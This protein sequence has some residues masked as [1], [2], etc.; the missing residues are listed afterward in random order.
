MKRL[1]FIA[2][3]ICVACKQPPKQTAQPGAGPQV[4]ATVIAVRTTAGE[5]ATNHEIVI[6]NGRARSTGEHEVWRL[7]DTKA[8]TVT[9]VDDIEKTYRTEPLASLLQ[10]RRQVLAA[11]LPSHYAAAK[12]I[13]GDSKPI[14]GRNAQQHVIQ[15][16][17]YRRELWIGTH[18]AIPDE[19][20]SMMLASDT[21]STPLAPMMRRVDE[22]LLRVKGFPLV[23]RSEVPLAK[24]TNVIERTVTGI[25][26]RQVP[27]AMLA[28][29]R[30]Y[31][32]VTPKPAS[33]KTKAAP[34]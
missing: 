3:A 16:G 29:P 20:Y 21:P 17:A 25:A 1:F 34:R 11:A 33:T 28:I 19:L 5:Q 23:D 24:S 14:L 6:V 31:R 8:D 15:A 2:I 4:A 12:L 30:E 10:K 32:D 13:H 22:E 26:S 7:Y 9:F 18:P 27:E